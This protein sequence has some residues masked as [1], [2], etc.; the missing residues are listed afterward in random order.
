M[1]N[2]IFSS[3]SWVSSPRPPQFRHHHPSEVISGNL[4]STTFHKSP[5]EVSELECKWL[6]MFLPI[7][8]QDLWLASCFFS[9]ITLLPIL[10]VSCVC[11]FPSASFKPHPLINCRGGRVNEPTFCS[12]LSIL[13]FFYFF[14]DAN[15]FIPQMLTRTRTDLFF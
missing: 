3:I 13:P 15:I 6:V 2:D 5:H 12:L 9:Y 4:S 8:S 7:Y 14:L 10:L 11:S 1:P